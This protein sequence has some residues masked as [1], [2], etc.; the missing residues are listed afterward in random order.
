MD[1]FQLHMYVIMI[2]ACLIVI[3]ALVIFLVLHYQMGKKNRMARQ[4]KGCALIRLR[5][6]LWQGFNSTSNLRIRRIDGRKAESFLYKWPGK[7]AVYVK[8]GT[9][10]IEARAEWDVQTWPIGSWFNYKVDTLP[11]VTVEADT[12]YALEYEVED[13]T[14]TLFRLGKTHEKDAHEVVVGQFKN[15]GGKV[16]DYHLRLLNILVVVI[17]IVMILFINFA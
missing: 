8:P 9:H 3:A 10:D 11:S 13:D 14:W 4:Y 2:F 17:L 12:E 16:C 15:L 1:F 7:R 6:K 5:T